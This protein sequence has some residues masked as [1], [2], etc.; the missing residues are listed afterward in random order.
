MA[1]WCPHSKHKRIL[2]SD[3]CNALDYWGECLNFE[4]H[5]QGEPQSLFA[6]V[7]TVP[8]CLEPIYTSH[9]HHLP[10]P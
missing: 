7:P 6:I 3:T 10:G 4:C 9:F 1:V 5:W 2:L 8:S